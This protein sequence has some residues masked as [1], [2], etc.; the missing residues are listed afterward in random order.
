MNYLTDKF[1]WFTQPSSI[2]SKNETL[3]GYV[4]AG[5]LVL[6]VILWLVNKF[7][8]RNQVVIKLVQRFNNISLFFGIGGLIWFVFRYENTPIFARRYWMGLTIVIGLVWLLFV[9]KYLAFNFVK[10]LNEYKRELIKKKYMP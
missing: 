9:I 6:S 7:L 4:F 5:F 8:L 10:D 1:F 3:S 2:L